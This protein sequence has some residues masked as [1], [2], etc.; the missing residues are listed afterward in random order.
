MLA[1]SG[2]K[3]KKTAGGRKGRSGPSAEELAERKE[4][5]DIERRLAVAREKDDVAVITA[6]E[7]QKDLLSLIG[8]YKNAGLSTAQA[9]VAAEQDLA[10]IEMARMG[11]ALED[12]QREQERNVIRARGI[13]DEER[14]LERRED[15]EDR[16]KDYQ[17]AG[18]AIDEARALAQRDMFNLTLALTEAQDKALLQRQADLEMQEAQLRNDHEHIRSLEQER[19]LAD[20]IADYQQIGYDLASAE[21]AAQQDLLRI[22]EARAEMIERRL[23]A[24]ESARQIELAQ[25]RGDS[26]SDIRKMEERARL[27]DR[28]DELRGDS[29]MSY[30]DALAQAQREANDRSLAHTQGTFR[31]AFRNGLQAAMDGNL[32]DFFENWMRERA[33]NALS[34]VLDKL[35]DNLANLI[36]GQN[37]GGLG[38]F[39]S[40]AFGLASGGKPAP[41]GGVSDWDNWS[42]MTGVPKLNTGGTGI[43]KGHP[44]IDKNLLS[45]NGSPV[46][47]VSQGERLKVEAA[48][49]NGG[50]GQTR[51]SVEASPFFDVRVNGQIAA[52]SP[53]IMQGGAQIASSRLSRRQSR[54]I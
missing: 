43:I 20:A 36:S 49:Q 31:D 35:A 13:I 25:L 42:Q 33:F 32:G 26:D 34:K 38:G 50:G 5:L 54:S 21:I 40:S 11:A 29:D 18:V 23:E 1:G 16:I 28:I 7:R 48:N 2:G 53:A 15:L 30:V 6:L 37:G 10:E 52:S 3:K 17:D 8:R 19:Y 46:A 12:I 27:A 39:L 47:W 22:E 44:G 9:R 24:Q 45:M 41:A 14:A 4:L 51:I